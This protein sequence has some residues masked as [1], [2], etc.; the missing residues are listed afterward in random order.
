MHVVILPCATSM[1][2]CPK[3]RPS[4]RNHSSSVFNRIN[5]AKLE[6][7]IYF[8]GINQLHW[9]ASF[10]LTQILQGMAPTTKETKRQE[11]TKDQNNEMKAKPME[12]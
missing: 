12:F 5:H 1:L 9:L 8:K 3:S 11:I 2:P 10:F 7:L 4:K 6:K